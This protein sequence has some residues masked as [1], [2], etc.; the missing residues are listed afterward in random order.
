MLRI[1]PELHA[2]LAVEATEQR[3]SLNQWVVRKLFGRNDSRGF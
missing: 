3:M 1:S 2:L